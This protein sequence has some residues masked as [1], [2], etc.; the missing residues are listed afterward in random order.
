MEDYLFLYRR[1]AKLTQH[2]MGSRCGVT[3]QYISEIE[4]GRARLTEGMARRICQVLGLPEYKVFPK[5][6]S[7]VSNTLGIYQVHQGPVAE[8]PLT[9]LERALEVWQLNENELTDEQIEILSGALK[10]AKFRLF[11]GRYDR[12]GN[13]IQKLEEGGV[14]K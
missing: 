10:E 6:F 13:S 4:T 9:S 5:F 1:K 2:E 3:G 7:K 12:L 8:K 14:K 11:P